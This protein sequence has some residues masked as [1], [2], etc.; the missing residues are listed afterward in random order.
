[1]LESQDWVTHKIS[2][3]LPLHLVHVQ[4]SYFTNLWT[5]YCEP[6]SFSKVLRT[7][8]L[9]YLQTIGNEKDIEQSWNRRSLNRYMHHVSCPRELNLHV[10]ITW[11]ETPRKVWRTQTIPT[12]M[13]PQ[14]EL[15]QSQGVMSKVRTSSCS[16]KQSWDSPNNTQSQSELGLKE[17]NQS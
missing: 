5:S 9:S 14:S 11:S 12:R 17:R 16:P 10:L 4:T 1:M 6:S 8:C 3:T 2:Y 7:R 13:W 15:G